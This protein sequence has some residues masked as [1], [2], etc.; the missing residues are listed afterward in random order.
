MGSE[1][2]RKL[3][4][5]VMSIKDDTSQNT[6]ETREILNTVTHLKDT[7]DTALQDLVA[8]KREVS[9]IR[10]QNKSFEERLD[11]LERKDRGKNAAGTTNKVLVIN[12]MPSNTNE[13]QLAKP[14]P[15]KPESVPAP[16]QQPKSQVLYLLV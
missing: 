7:V 15:Q 9:A 14:L 13:Q 2:I 6:G 16:S 3:K 11:T 5:V 8:L 10:E 4:E 1:E 12:K